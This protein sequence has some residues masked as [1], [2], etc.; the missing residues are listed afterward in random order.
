[1]QIT[2][3]K[4]TALQAQFSNEL[5]QLLCSIRENALNQFEYNLKQNIPRDILQPD[6][7][8]GQAISHGVVSA[9]SRRNDWGIEPSIQF[10]H[11]I[12][13]DVNA[14]IEAAALNQFITA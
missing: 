2:Q 14:H 4:K 13:E 5:N 6:E 1:M 12:L 8:V 3:A 10:A 7:V 11:D 9:I